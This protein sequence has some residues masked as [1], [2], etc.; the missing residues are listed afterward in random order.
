MVIAKPMQV[1]K[2]NAVPLVSAGTDCAVNAENCGESAITKKLQ[3]NIK[4]KNKNAELLIKNGL[5]RQQRPDINNDKAAT[6]LL[7][8]VSETTPPKIHPNAPVAII[9]ND[10]KETSSC[11]SKNEL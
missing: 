5:A 2:V 8:R 3:T 9:I 6:F 11:S 7:P 4:D 10:Q 1:T